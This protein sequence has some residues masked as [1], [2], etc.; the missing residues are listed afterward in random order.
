MALG[1]R[2]VFAFPLVTRAACF[3]VLTFY[4][5][6]SD[7]LSVEQLADA[8]DLT[9]LA[10]EDLLH[11]HAE[12]ALPWLLSYGSDERSCVYQACGMV[13]AQI[14]SDM[15]TAMAHIRAYA[16]AHELTIFETANMV[17]TRQLRLTP[18]GFN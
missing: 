6:T 16:F 15:A 1:L 13:G 14:K 5:D 12:G 8:L 9:A 18:H 11:L 7:A 3:G 4:R 10:A 2:S 17:V